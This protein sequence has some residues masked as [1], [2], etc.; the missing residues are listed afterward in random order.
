MCAR[1]EKILKF[2]DLNDHI[3]KFKEQEQ[4]MPKIS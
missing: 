4:N 1:K 3:E 2:N